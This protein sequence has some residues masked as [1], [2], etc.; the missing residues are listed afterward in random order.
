MA[1]AESEANRNADENKEMLFQPIR[2]GT[3][4]LAHRVVLAPLGR[5]R[6][7]NEHIPTELM[8]EYYARRAGVPGTLLVTES[9]TIAPRA[10][11][12]NNCPGIW[13]D[14]QIS[15]WKKVR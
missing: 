14:E 12:Y 5:F 1:Q 3:M 6:A 15:G 9:T 11:G 7:D 13:S 8:V 4:E 10:G 2:V